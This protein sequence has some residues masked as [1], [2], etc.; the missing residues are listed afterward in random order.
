MPLKLGIRTFLIKMLFEYL[1]EK[2]QGKCMALFVKTIFVG[3][4]S[5]QKL[6]LYFKGR[7]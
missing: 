6:I 2:L 7:T 4:D 3:F 5:T 1:K